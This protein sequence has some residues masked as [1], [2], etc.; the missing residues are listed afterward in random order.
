MKY[1]D[2][3][4]RFAAAMKKGEKQDKGRKEK[5]SKAINKLKK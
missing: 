2:L 3:E 5:I 4:S 1:T